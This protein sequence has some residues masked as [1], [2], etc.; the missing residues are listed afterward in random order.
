MPFKIF[1]C[2]RYLLF[3]LAFSVMVLVLMIARK[4]N[5]KIRFCFSSFICK[6]FCLDLKVNGE[7]DSDAQLLLVN[8]RSLMDIVIIEYLISQKNTCW[9]AKKEITDTIFIGQIIK[10]T[11]MISLDREDKRG[12]LKLLK[13]VKTKSEEGTLVLIFPE[14]TRNKTAGLLPFKP[15]AKFLAEKLKL[16]VQAVV[17]HDTEKLLSANDV[18]FKVRPVRLDILPSF[19]TAESETWFDDLQQ[20]MLAIL[21]QSN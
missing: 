8:H 14:G 2:C 18:F 20:Q 16:K 5:K 19:K 9:I 7:F 6:V 17:L 3:V 21:K 4:Y 11:N 12:L 1:T 10:A 15:G 13:S